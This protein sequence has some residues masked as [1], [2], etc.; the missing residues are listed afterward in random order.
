MPSYK[1]RWKMNDE[2]QFNLQ[3]NEQILVSLNSV[4]KVRTLMNHN[5]AILC[6]DV[7]QKR[8]VTGGAD[9]LI[10]VYETNELKCL[11]KLVGHKVY[12]QISLFFFFFCF[13]LFFK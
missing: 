1:L 6:M 4:K 8:L 12:A 9:R 13:F 10:F 11:G 5:D 7:D 3:P 2:S